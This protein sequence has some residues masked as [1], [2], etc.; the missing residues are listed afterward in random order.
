MSIARPRSSAVYPR[1]LEPRGSPLAS[2]TTSTTVSGLLQHDQVA[3]DRALRAPLPRAELAERYARDTDCDQPRGR[4]ES[5]VVSGLIS[6]SQMIGGSIGLAALAGVAAVR[7]AGLL[8]GGLVEP[9]A[10]LHDGYHVA[11]LAAAVLAGLTE[12]LAA[13]QLRSAPPVQQTPVSI[14]AMR[15]YLAA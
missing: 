10:A 4:L 6:T 3:V 5:D 9:R 13:T 2:Q 12:V 11:F 7:T 14:E 15:H 8:A 1:R